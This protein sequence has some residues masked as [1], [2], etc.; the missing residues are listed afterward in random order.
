MSEGG[1]FKHVRSLFRKQFDEIF[2]V[3]LSLSHNFDKNFV[4][5]TFLLKKK[6]EWSG[7]WKNVIWLKKRK[8]TS[9]FSVRKTV[10]K[11]QHI[12]ATQIL[13]EIYFDHFGASK[14]AILTTLAALDVEL[15][16]PTMWKCENLSPR[17]FF[18]KISSK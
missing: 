1:R 10:C 16:S 12:S 18:V 7:L 8:T 2:P 9:F 6:R 5:V 17:F 15:F 4:K 11:F 14:T 13:R 3:I